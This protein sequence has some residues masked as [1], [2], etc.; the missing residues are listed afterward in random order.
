MS[1]VA[2]R[3]T[4]LSPRKRALLE[5]RLR[6][7]AARP[8]TFPLS[9]AQ[10]QLWLL[11]QLQPDNPAY[12]ICS[13]LRLKGALDLFA[14]EQALGEIERRHEMLR[15][16]FIEVDEQPVQVVGP[17]RRLRLPIV[18]LSGQTEAAQLVWAQ[19][20][21]A[22]EARGPFVLASGPLWRHRL[23]RLGPHDHAVIFTMHHIVSDGWSM[24]LLVRE[25]VQLYEAF[26]HG[27]S[28]PLAELPIQYA[29]YTRWQRETAQGDTLARQL[30][31]WRR[32]LE[33]APSAL[34]LP[35]DRPRA[36]R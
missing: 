23:L 34:A 5:L 21:I 24:G 14:F 36:Q 33:G 13:T 3:I 20:N 2:E 19:V 17:A 12:N 25:L 4:A 15:T 6:Q 27:Q 26:A 32:Q 11:N 7:Q 28:S 10:E 1:Q 16:T 30:D 9:F 35:T 18:D 29:D 22:R 31:Y 8:R